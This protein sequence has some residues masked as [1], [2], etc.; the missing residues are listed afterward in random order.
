MTDSVFPVLRGQSWPVVRHTL[1]KTLVD[2][3]LSRR[4]STLAL[5]QYPMYEWEVAFEWLADNATPSDIRSIVGLYNQ[6]Q[7]RADTFLYRDPIFNAVVAE[8]FG[9]GDGVTLDFQLVAK[10][11]NVGG[12][13]A[14]DII[15]NF[16]GA[17][18]IFD[19]GGLP[20]PHL[21]GPSGIVSFSPAP[22]PGHILTWTGAFYYRCRFS[23][24]TLETSDFMANWWEVK[25]LKFRSIL[26]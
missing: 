8:P 26:L 25:S 10:F 14:S 11:A 22:S 24:D 1:F 15:Q 4:V 13:G 12:A 9:V 2:E 3:A 6:C 16:N 5:Q 19:N 7:G 17:P 18:Q 23:D 20:N 21:L